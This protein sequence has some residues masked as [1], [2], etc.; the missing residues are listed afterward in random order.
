MLYIL[1]SIL[2]GITLAA[3]SAGVNAQSLTH[4]WVNITGG[5]G[6]ESVAKLATDIN[7]N[8]FVA[9][10]FYNTVDFD[11]T[12]GQNLK[13]SKGLGDCYIQKLNH[14]GELLWIAS[15][16]GIKEDNIYSVA[17]DNSGNVYA[18]G[19]FHDTVDF[20]PGTNTHKLY[21][22]IG[23]FILKLDSSGN[24][25]WVKSLSGTITN[26]AKIIITQDQ[27]ILIAGNYTGSVDF[28]PDAGV[29]KLT[30]STIYVNDAQ[31]AF[32]CKYNGSSGALLWAKEFRTD[33]FAVEL[34][35]VSMDNDGNLISCGYY[36]FIVDLDP[37]T[38]TNKHNVANEGFQEG[39][40]SKLSPDG[41]FIW[42]RSF[43]ASSMQNYTIT[44][45]QLNNV[46]VGGTFY[47]I[48]DFDPGPG[49]QIESS[50]NSDM[51]LL[52]LDKNG[53][54]QWVKIIRVD[55]G[56]TAIMRNISSD[57]MNNTLVSGFFNNSVDFDPGINNYKLA[58]GK[59][60][61]S[62]F[63]SK[64]NS[65]GD[66]IYAKKI[67]NGLTATEAYGMDLDITG[68]VYLSGYFADSSEFQIN[69][70]VIKRT[71]NA[72]ST[73]AFVQ[74]ANCPIGFS[75][76]QNA[77]TLTVNTTASDIQWI[78]CS[79][80]KPI[81]NETHKTFIPKI[82]GEYSVAMNLG[83]YTVQSSC[84]SVTNA[85]TNTINFS[86]IKL[87][88]NPTNTVLHVASSD[89]K[90]RTYEIH[91]LS[92]RIIASD[93]IEEDGKAINTSYLPDGVYIISLKDT[94][95]NMCSLQFICMHE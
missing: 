36:N 35:D 61:R 28:D 43:N 7:Q 10:N 77:G 62:T 68:N 80:N 44:S 74:K 82:N 58:S 32:L 15:W 9:G 60:I 81:P 6:S 42:G 45:D 76:Q 64:Y 89:V 54:F 33:K 75:I 92:G 41:N 29:Y 56:S 90:F 88:P 40:V 21:E 47:A 1:K 39:F 31:N 86:R 94:A 70:A 46:T 50:G 66:F 48:V 72:Y 52:Q 14:N 91:E 51:F 26:I 2:I 93:I 13:T 79:N 12:L 73:D 53:T 3:L 20:D 5:P 71:S 37:G 17:T 95:G 65:S 78:D 25:K 87:F 11:P 63:I 4:E 67:G 19:Y 30:V 16:G 85:G 34:K 27:N 22:K 83:E 38:G 59:Y 55:P 69:S 84:Y 8:V 18:V 23:F 49:E 24:F 57:P